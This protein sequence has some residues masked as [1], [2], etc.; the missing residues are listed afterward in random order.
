MKVD[1]YI[2]IGGSSKRFGSDK[3]AF[4]FHGTTLAERAAAIVEEAFPRARATYVAAREDQFSGLSG[5]RTIFDT[6][7]ESGAVGAV[8]TA[9]ID[10]TAEWTLIMACDLPFVSALFI[11]HLLS[12]T[13]E[14]NAVV[15]VQKDGRWQPLCAFYQ[16]NV[17]RNA[18][19]AYITQDERLPSLRAIVESIGVRPVRFE[20]YVFLGD[21]ERL[22]TNVNMPG[23]LK[24]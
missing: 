7:S 13:G 21:A 4:V 9:L 19:A 15:P 10:A 24:S 17:C 16:T 14:S 2:L 6:R 20:D 22:L 18:I 12:F 3:A 5:R 23:D 8:Y 11:K 1:P